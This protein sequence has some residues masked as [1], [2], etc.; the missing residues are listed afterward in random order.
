MMACSVVLVLVFSCKNEPKAPE[1]PKAVMV[2]SLSLDKKGGTDCDQPDTMR[3]NCVEINLKYPA[4]EQGSDALKQ[5]VTAWAN[6]FLVGVLAPET[7][8]DSA[9]SVSLE[10]AA[11]GFIAS[12][13]Q[14]AEESGGS[15]MGYWVAESH[16]TTLLNDG[17]H[18]TLEISSYSYAGGAHGS[19]MAAVATFDVESGK[20]LV[21][22]DLVTDT[23]A[24][25]ALLE[26]KYREV[27]A[28]LFQPT[29]GS[30]PFQFDDIF[31]FDLPVNY[32]L[33][34]D[35]LYCHYLHYE[36]GPYAIGNTQFVLPYAEL[37]ALSKIKQ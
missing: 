24:L 12:H 10:A 22:T 28:D 4:V 31:V 14:F 9:A 27:R 29:D 8:A 17:K 33:V 32:G 19:P 15:V 13:K 11:D 36:V 35:G 20:Q 2:S 37:G 25:K 6:S 3:M 26:K 18:L 30:E 34:K 21:W 7:N 1:A 5:G 23:E 16:D